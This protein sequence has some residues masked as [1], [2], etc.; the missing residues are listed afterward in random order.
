[1]PLFKNLRVGVHW[2]DDKGG[3]TLPITPLHKLISENLK[4]KIRKIF[5]ECEKRNWVIVLPNPPADLREKIR[6]VAQIN[7]R[8]VGAEVQKILEK[9]VEETPL[10]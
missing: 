9:F 4:Q 1:M 8:Q 10:S 3:C 5:M 7:G 2:E 6:A